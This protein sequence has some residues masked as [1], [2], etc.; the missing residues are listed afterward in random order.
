MIPTT[1]QPGKGKAKAAVERPRAARGWGRKERTG[2][3]KAAFQAVTLLSDTIMVAKGHFGR[4]NP[5]VNS[6]LHRNVSI[7]VYQLEQI[8]PCDARC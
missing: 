1:P 3:A 6:G 4:M 8:P 7:L 5:G 2:G